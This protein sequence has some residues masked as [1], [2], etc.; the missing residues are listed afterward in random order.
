M[1]VQL[2]FTGIGCGWLNSTTNPPLLRAVIRY[3]PS[4]NSCGVAVTVGGG[5]RLLVNET[6]PLSAPAGMVTFPPLFWQLL[7]EASDLVP[8]STRCFR[9]VS[10]CSLVVEECMSCIWIYYLFVVDTR[11]LK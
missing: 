3:D 7:Q 1:A 2:N 6:C 4:I 9:A 5:V 8:R 10:I 11:F